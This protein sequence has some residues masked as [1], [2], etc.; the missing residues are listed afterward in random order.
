M[1][2]QIDLAA[3]VSS[4]DTQKFTGT[5]ATFCQIDEAWGVKIF[6]TERQRDQ[7]YD[8]QRDYETVLLA[9]MTG[10]KVEFYYKGAKRYGFIT[11][12]CEPC[13]GAFLEWCGSEKTEQCCGEDYF[14]GVDDHYEYMERFKDFL[15]D[16]SYWEARYNEL[17]VKLLKNDIYFEDEHAGNWGINQMGEPVIIDFSRHFRLL[18]P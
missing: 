13:D 2:L 18:N 17:Q 12:Y 5:H 14:L 8:L 4:P 11:E 16:N 1:D 3:H 15:E 6:P 7:N 10:P 9:P